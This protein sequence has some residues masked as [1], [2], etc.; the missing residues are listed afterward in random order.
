MPRRLNALKDYPDV[1]VVSEIYTDWTGSKAQSELNS[2]LPT[3][4]KVD[5]L[6]TQG[7]DAY[8]AVQAFISAGYTEL[9]VIAGDNRGSFLKWWMNE[10]PEGYETISGACNPWDGAIAMYIAVDILNGEKVENNMNDT[11]ISGYIEFSEPPELAKA[12]KTDIGT[13]GANESKD[14]TINVPDLKEKGL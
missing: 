3:L 2:V 7:G 5:G 9:P 14:I 10:A 8:A 1:K 4:D 12:G 13:I 11:P 6:V